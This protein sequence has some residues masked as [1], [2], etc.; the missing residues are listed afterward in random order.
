LLKEAVD[1]RKNLRD[2]W[3]L[4]EVHV[5]NVFPYLDLA[6][7]N[8]LISDKMKNEL[9]EELSTLSKMLSRLKSSL[10]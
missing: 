3:I 1:L 2:F 10:R 8:N 5:L 4:T 6:F 9:L 7:K